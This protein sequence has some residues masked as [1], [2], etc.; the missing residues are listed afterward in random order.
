MPPN[1]PTSAKGR[2][3]GDYEPPILTEPEG[4]PIPS[5]RSRDGL[6]RFNPNQ[7]R[8]PDGQWSDGIPGSL[9]GL[10]RFNPGRGAFGSSDMQANAVVVN[11]PGGREVHLGVSPSNPDEGDEWDGKPDRPDTVTLS[12][13]GLRRL[14]NDLDEGRTAAKAALAAD[15]DDFGELASGSTSGIT[16]SMY[17]EDLAP[18]STSITIDP[19]ADSLVLDPKQLERFVRWLDEL[20]GEMGT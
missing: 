3:A 18:F 15:P 8:D 20:D 13:R 6:R 4:G 1:A 7:P 19:E 16:W 10:R 17:G 11:G 14:R 12:R 2:Q 5:T 9:G